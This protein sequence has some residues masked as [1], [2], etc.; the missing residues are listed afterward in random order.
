MS[1]AYKFCV[2]SDDLG[3]NFGCKKAGLL[4]Y[5]TLLLLLDFRGI[6]FYRRYSIEYARPATKRFGE[7]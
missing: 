7:T 4:F 5:F 2:S 6:L 3:N 1:S